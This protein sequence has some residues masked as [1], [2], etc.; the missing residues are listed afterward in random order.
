IVVANKI[1]LR[2]HSIG[3]ALPR[4]G[5]RTHSTAAEPLLQDSS[6]SHHQISAKTGQGIDELRR[7]IAKQVG[8]EHSEGGTFSARARHVDAL[9]RAQ[10]H[11]DSARQHLDHIALEL[12]AEELRLAHEA[13][14]EITG[15]VTADDLLGEIFSRFCIGK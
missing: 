9:K 7:A 14:G 3:A 4:T 2:E 6:P 8:Y 15:E 5:G 12:F 10:H 11:I 13:L 1:D